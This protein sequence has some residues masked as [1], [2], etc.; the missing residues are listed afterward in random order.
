M[1]EAVAV[2]IFLIQACHVQEQLLLP[3]L[4]NSS[5][6][7]KCCINIVQKFLEALLCVLIPMDMSR[8]SL[9][10]L[11]YFLILTQMSHQLLSF[12]LPSRF[13]WKKGEVCS[14]L[15]LFFHARLS[16]VI[17]HY[18][19]KLVFVVFSVRDWT[20]ASRNQGKHYHWATPQPHW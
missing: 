2:V 20:Q 14:F 10:H 19:S 6:D 5:E 7:C 1:E 18:F 16:R 12:V 15:A 11:S 17:F 9:R 13:S 4:N 8:V 3:D